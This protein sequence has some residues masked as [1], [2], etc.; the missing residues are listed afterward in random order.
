[1]TLV[2]LQ[3]YVKDPHKFARISAGGQKCAFFHPLRLWE[4]PRWLNCE[5]PASDVQGG[6]RITEPGLVETC[7][8]EDR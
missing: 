5:Q 2:T 4:A 1:M 8:T 7:L 6:Q 3:G